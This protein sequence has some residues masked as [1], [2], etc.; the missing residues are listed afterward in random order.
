MLASF[1]QIWQNRRKISLPSTKEALIFLFFVV[2]S[3]FFWFLYTLSKPYE[4]EVSIPVS[5][6]NIP[7]QYLITGALPK[8]IN[9]TL[10]GMGI[11][12]LF[13]KFDLKDT[14]KID[15]SKR[16]DE[17]GENFL[18]PYQ[19]LRQHVTD[20][21]SMSFSVQDFSPREI[22]VN[23]ERLQSKRLPVVLPEEVNLAQQYVLKGAINLTPDSVMVYASQEIL[24]Q[25]SEVRLKSLQLPAL[26]K[27][28]SRTIEIQ[29]VANVRYHPKQV[30]VD[31]PVEMATEKALELPVMGVNFPSDV[32]LR[33][34]PATVEVRFLV[35][36]SLF[37]QITEKDIQVYLDYKTLISNGEEKQQLNYYTSKPGISNLKIIP[38][39]VEYIM[40]ENGLNR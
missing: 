37:E 4:A 2:I 5:Y 11:N 21:I 38:D 39:A 23:F 33:T 9:L 7:E 36:L 19:E 10:K 18:I 31:I 27:T 32:Q 12:L 25:M 26:V 34:F 15:M 35:G 28:T 1:K 3:T 22:T 20:S 14:L 13:A 17:K 8:E 16:F 40:E 6:R 29:P 30:Q 24:S